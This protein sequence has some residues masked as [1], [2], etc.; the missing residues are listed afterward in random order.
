MKEK[1]RQKYYFRVCVASA[2]THR[3]LCVVYHDA[4]LD[5][6]ER[7]VPPASGESRNSLE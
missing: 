6:L 2:G 7:R 4:E 1:V 5:Y 3:D